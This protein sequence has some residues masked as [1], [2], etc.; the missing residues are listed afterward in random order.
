MDKSDIFGYGNRGSG[1]LGGMLE[2]FDASL[3]IK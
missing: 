2:S 3:S 1:I